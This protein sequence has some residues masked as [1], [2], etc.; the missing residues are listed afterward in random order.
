VNTLVDDENGWEIPIVKLRWNG[1]WSDGDTG[2]E[3]KGI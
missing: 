2:V 3:M 1:S